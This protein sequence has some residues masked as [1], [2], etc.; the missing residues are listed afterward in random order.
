MAKLFEFKEGYLNG[1]TAKVVSEEAA[2]L[3]KNTIVTRFNV[4][5]KTFTRHFDDTIVTCFGP[6]PDGSCVLRIQGKPNGAERRVTG[7]IEI[8]LKSEHELQKVLTSDLF[9]DG[10]ASLK[11]AQFVGYLGEQHV[12][13]EIKKG[14]LFDK[15]FM[16]TRYGKAPLANKSSRLDKD[17]NELNSL[18]GKRFV[19][20]K[21][22]AL[23]NAKGQG[24]DLICKI[25]PP[26][27]EW[28]TFEI[29][30]T[31]KDKFG[32]NATPK[33]GEPS[34]AQKD[35]IGNISKHTGLANIS[36]V[37]G[38][39]DYNLSRAQRKMLVEIKKDISKSNI[40][41]FK[42]TVAID[43]KLNVSSNN[44]YGS[45]YIVEAFK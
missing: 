3:L 42:L 16:K 17:G 44:K 2:K 8:N 11:M 30:T 32:P 13:N 39:N 38:H 1:I 15:L 28:V 5:G 40:A 33:S 18:L 45:F 34:E 43:D 20:E 4:V 37:Q 10:L 19:P 29:K 12:V 24:I 26:P 23:Q 21:M 31:M 6:K 35:Y 27:P 7:H 22:L 41:G 9:Y 14:T 36:F 25:E